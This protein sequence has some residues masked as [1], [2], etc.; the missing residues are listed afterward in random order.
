M[1]YPDEAQCFRTPSQILAASQ[2]FKSK[3]KNMKTG[4][5]GEG[6]GTSTT[7][8]SV[9]LIDGIWSKGPLFYRVGHH[10]FI[11]KIKPAD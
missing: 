9:I 2:S 10:Q 11:L 7:T 8:E 3:N 1:D 6:G 4:E 5:E